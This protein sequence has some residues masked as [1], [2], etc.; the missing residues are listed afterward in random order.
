MIDSKIISRLEDLKYLGK[1]KGA[2]VSIISKKSEYH[3]VVKFFAQINSD[4]RIQKISYQA[5]GCT[6]FMAMCSFFC[7]LVEGMKVSSALKIT[8]EDLDKVVKVEVSNDHVYP[9]IFDT[10][11]LLIKKYNK[12]VESGKITPAEVVENKASSNNASKKN[13]KNSVVIDKTLEKYLENPSSQKTPKK[14]RVKSEKLTIIE[15]T[16]KEVKEESKEKAIERKMEDFEIKEKFSK[17]IEK[18]NKPKKEKKSKQAPVC[19]IIIEEIKDEIIVEDK[20]EK[21]E[22][23]KS[24]KKQKVV[25]TKDEKVS[26]IIEEIKPDVIHNNELEV[27]TVD[28][29]ENLPS[30]EILVVEE[31]PQIQLEEKHIVKVVEIKEEIEVKKTSDD[32]VEMK[33]TKKTNEIHLGHLSSLQEKLKTKENHDKSQHNLH[34]LNSLLQKMEIKKENNVVENKDTSILESKKNSKDKK[35]KKDKK[36]RKSLFAW[37]KKK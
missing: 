9:I 8:R 12:G 2:N 18:D 34:S 13:A 29:S 3:D 37:F 35:E 33:T 16:L 23:K 10:F 7:E 24:P 28:N 17:V 25:K 11:Q 26:E 32:V 20:K 1:T 27:D 19:P 22:K 14:E 21:T 4:N 31:K 36:E 5:S 15:E 30:T 6:T